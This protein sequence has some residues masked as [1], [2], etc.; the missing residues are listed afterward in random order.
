MSGVFNAGYVMAIL[1]I[2]YGCSDKIL[3]CMHSVLFRALILEGGTLETFFFYLHVDKLHPRS[4][5]TVS[6][7]RAHKLKKDWG[8][9][10]RS[11]IFMPRTQFNH[12]PGT[13]INA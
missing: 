3:S 9:Y 2:M 5:K 11:Q 7:L 12:H 1:I 6:F 4:A 10:S 13:S 8:L